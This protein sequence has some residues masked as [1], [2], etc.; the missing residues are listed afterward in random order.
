MGFFVVGFV[1]FFDTLL[2]FG[3]R[4]APGSFCI[5]LVLAISPR[6]PGSSY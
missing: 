3:T 4:D 6:N 1:L 5:I 2:L